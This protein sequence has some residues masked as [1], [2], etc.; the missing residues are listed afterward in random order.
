MLSKNVINEVVKEWSWRVPTGMPDVK[1]TE[2]LNILR[3]LLI[4]DFKASTYTVNQVIHSLSEVKGKKWISNALEKELKS[5]N[6][7]TDFNYFIDTTCSTADIRKSVKVYIKKIT[8]AAKAKEFVQKLG[9]LSKPTN[10]MSVNGSVE[11]AMYA[12]NAKGI[13]TGEIWLGY[14]VKNS[15]IQGGSVSFDLLV[16]G[17]KYEVKDYATAGPSTAIRVGVEGNVAQ[18]GFWR[19]V[20]DTLITLEKVFDEM[21]AEDLIEQPDFIKVSKEMLSRKTT[22]S[23]GEWNKT[24]VGTFRDFYTITSNLTAVADTGFNQV[25]FIGPNQKPITK[26]IKPIDTIPSTQVTVKFVKA[27]SKYTQ[28]D[29]VN[30]LRKLSYIRKPSDYDKGLKRAIKDIIDKGTAAEWIIFRKSGIKVLKGSS[31]FKF[32]H[33]SQGGVRIL[34]L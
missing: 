24:D 33:V 29:V 22:I 9:R 8:A 2:H 28:L 21:G 14:V 12:L 13:G 18:H 4:T 7:M 17:T 26:T 15:Q 20:L 16:S 3:D 31:K 23:T 19:Q 32:S 10:G 1:S 30:A 6:K 27:A 34:D 25:K 5:A 11:K